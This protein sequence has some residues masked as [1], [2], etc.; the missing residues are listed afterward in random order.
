MQTAGT[1]LVLM[2]VL[3]MFGIFENFIKT[4]IQWF[5]YLFVGMLIFLTGFLYE[6]KSEETLSSFSQK[7]KKEKLNNCSNAIYLVLIVIVFLISQLL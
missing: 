4:D 6:I 5:L 7:R 1:L 3:R 2:F